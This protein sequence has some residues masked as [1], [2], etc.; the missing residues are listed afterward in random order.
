MYSWAS[1]K[2]PTK[3][4]HC[5]LSKCVSAATHTR[6]LGVISSVVLLCTDGLFL[7]Q[8]NGVANLGRYFMLKVKPL[9]LDAE[10]EYYE[11]KILRGSLALDDS[12][13][14]KP[15]LGASFTV[16]WCSQR[17][18]T[19]PSYLFTISQTFWLKT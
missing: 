2:D 4:N 6:K 13:S 17:P 16:L 19:K 15:G 11:G 7:N 10:L 18:R 12:L 5:M 14:I 1:K 9:L 8:H 3:K